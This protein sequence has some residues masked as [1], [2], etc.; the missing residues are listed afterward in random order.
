MTLDSIRNYCDV[1]IEVMIEFLT[2][3]REIRGSVSVSSSVSNFWPNALDALG[4]H[5][6]LGQAARRAAKILF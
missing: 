1:Y 2:S 5:M 4:P 6:H 3:K